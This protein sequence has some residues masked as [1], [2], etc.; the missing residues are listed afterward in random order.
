MR[1][2]LYILLLLF[3]S[4]CA[5]MVAPSGGEKDTSP[6]EIIRWQTENKNNELV[7]S[8]EF[9]EYIQF[10]NW[11][12]NFFISPPLLNGNIKRKIHEKTLV[13]RNDF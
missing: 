7:L 8:F 6:P 3:L 1:L 12:E 2:F 5:N 9:D 11:Q 4:G 13:S 10:A